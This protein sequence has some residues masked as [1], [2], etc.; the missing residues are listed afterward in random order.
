MLLSAANTVKWPGWR[1]IHTMW[2]WGSLL[3]L[4]APRDDPKSFV[5]V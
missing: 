5:L 2:V 1:H 3:E 4:G